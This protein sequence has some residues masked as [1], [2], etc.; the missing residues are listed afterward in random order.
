MNQDITI[1]YVNFFGIIVTR[2]E[3]VE[4]KDLRRILQPRRE[5]LT[6][7]GRTYRSVELNNC[8]GVICVIK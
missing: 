3:C 2:Y 5:R 1:S 7:E 6:E 8:F 4:I